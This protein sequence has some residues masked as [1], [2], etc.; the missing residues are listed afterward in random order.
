[1]VAQRCK[2]LGVIGLCLLLPTHAWCKDIDLD[3]RPGEGVTSQAKLSDYF[4][5]LKDSN[6]DTDIFILDSGVPGATGLMI[7]GTHGNEIAGSVADGYPQANCT[8]TPGS[9]TVR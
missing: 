2:W 1:M 6:L 9:I 8:S 5:P 4:Q 3:I 7:G